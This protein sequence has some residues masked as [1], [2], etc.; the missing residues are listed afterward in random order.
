MHIALGSLIRGFVGTYEF[1]RIQQTQAGVNPR[2]NQKNPATAGFVDFGVSSNGARGVRREKAFPVG[3]NPTRQPL[4]PEATGA[5]MEGTKW[6][7]PWSKS[8]ASL[9]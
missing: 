2:S 7:K 6:L 5:A 4:Q 3:A 1:L 9:A 8:Y